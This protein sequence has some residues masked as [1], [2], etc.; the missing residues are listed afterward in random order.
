MYEEWKPH[1]VKAVLLALC[2][3]APNTARGEH[4]GVLEVA[5]RL[6]RSGTANKEGSAV[7]EEALLVLAQRAADSGLSS[8]MLQDFC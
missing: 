7:Y 8:E 6:V 4:I 5:Q 1:V 2:K 3:H